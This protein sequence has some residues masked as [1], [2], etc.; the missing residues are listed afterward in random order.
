MISL[1]TKLLKVNTERHPLSRM[2]LDS[3]GRIG[4][5]RRAAGLICAP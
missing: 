4:L 3:D 5:I 1:D 2:F